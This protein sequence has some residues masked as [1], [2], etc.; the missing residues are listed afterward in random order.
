[1][2]I[3]NSKNKTYVTYMLKENGKFNKD[4]IITNLEMRF[5]NKPVNA[6]WGSPENAKLGWKEYC[7]QRKQSDI[8][9][10]HEFNE[11]PNIDLYYFKYEFND[12]NAI[13]WKL[14]E[15]SKIF[16]IDKEDMYE[17]PERIE[18]YLS[19]EVPVP[20]SFDFKKMLSDGI[21][22]IELIDPG[23]GH[24]CINSLEL[25]FH[26]WDCESIVV[27]DPSKIIFLGE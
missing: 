17:H 19:I 27:L 20:K 15:N 10:A 25:M 2:G 9:Y 14:E 21:V 4:K 18:K 6:F 16:T 11:E 12:N 26:D 13:K 1:M 23:I 24:R 3:I 5:N 8:Q 22:A 7:E